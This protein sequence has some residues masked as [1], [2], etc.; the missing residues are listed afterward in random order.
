M[1]ASHLLF[2]NDMLIF[3]EPSGEQLSNLRCIFLCFVVV[4]GLKINLSKSEIV[5]VGNVG[6]AE[7]LAG[8]L[9]C[10]VASLPT[11]NLGLPLGALLQFGM[12]LLRRWNIGWRVGKG[13]IYQI[14]TG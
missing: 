4:S 13:F 8:I 9:M 12:A 14:E 11:K 7:G 3:C 1:I 10:K 2:A 6:D 5:P